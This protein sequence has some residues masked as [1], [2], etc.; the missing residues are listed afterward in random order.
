MAKDFIE[1]PKSPINNMAEFRGVLY[2][3][4]GDSIYDHRD[5]KK[6]L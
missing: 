6:W 4:A 5:G 2:V 3:V 1:L